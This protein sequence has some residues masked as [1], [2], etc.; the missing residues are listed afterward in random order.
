MVNGQVK[1]FWIQKQRFPCRIG[2]LLVFLSHIMRC[3]FDNNTGEREK[4]DSKQ[5]KLLR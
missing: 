4:H 2:D 3:C 1:K 5:E